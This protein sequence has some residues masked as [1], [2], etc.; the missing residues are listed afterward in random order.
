MYWIDADYQVWSWKPGTDPKLE[1]ND[2]RELSTFYN[3]TGG[4]MSI[5]LDSDTER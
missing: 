3:Q 4:D 2:I 1:H 5:Q